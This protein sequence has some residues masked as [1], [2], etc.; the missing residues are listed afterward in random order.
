MLKD[1]FQDVGNVKLAEMRGSG[2]AIV[3]FASTLDA[4]RAVC[5][6]LKNILIV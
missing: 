5:I 4:E 6:L 1:K 2:V 3:Q